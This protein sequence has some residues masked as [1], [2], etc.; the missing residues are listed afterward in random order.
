MHDLGKIVIPDAILNK[1][2]KFTPEEFE[3]M[4]THAA[5]GGKIVHD[6]ISCVS[7]AVQLTQCFLLWKIKP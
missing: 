2:R 1:P 4:K 3:T 5:A 6:I 7:T